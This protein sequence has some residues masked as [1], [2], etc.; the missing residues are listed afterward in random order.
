MLLVYPG[1]DLKPI[2]SVR[3]KNLLFGIQDFNIFKDLE[4]NVL[5]KKEEIMQNIENV[6]G[7]KEE[8]KAIL[9]EEQDSIIDKKDTMKSVEKRNV[10]LN[11]SLD[12]EEYNLFRNSLIKKHII[13]R[14]DG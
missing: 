11:Y 4:K 14:K 12:I 1:K 2:S 3:E 10:K 7:K 13:N 8:M 9:E 5:G 6:L